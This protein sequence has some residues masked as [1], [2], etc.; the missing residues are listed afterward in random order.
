MTIVLL[1]AGILV[2]LSLWVL[3]WRTQVNL[4]FGIALGIMIDWVVAAVVGPIRFEQIQIW[5]PPLPFAII[6]VMLLCFGILAWRWDDQKPGQKSDQKSGQKPDEK[7]AAKTGS[8][9]SH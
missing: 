5:L 9:H 6:A 8:H 3:A 4:A 7:S 1:I 2:F